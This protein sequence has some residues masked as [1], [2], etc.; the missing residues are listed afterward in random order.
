MTG[1]D[2]LEKDFYAV[3]GVRKDADAAT[4]K[5]AY[6][7]LARNMHPSHHTRLTRYVRGKR[8]VVEIDHGVFAFP[9]TNAHGAGLCPQHVYGVRF[10]ARDLWGDAASPKDTLQIDLFADYL[11]PA[12][13]EPRA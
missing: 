3:L 10:K 5:K 12:G 13:E 9:D 1:Q 7:K 8:G 11:S 2:S 4:I 6:R